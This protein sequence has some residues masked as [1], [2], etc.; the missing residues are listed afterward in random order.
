M[1][2][3]TLEAPTSAQHT[4][5]HGSKR[6][7]AGTVSTKITANNSHCA[8][9]TASSHPRLFQRQQTLTAGQVLAAKQEAFASH[10]DPAG[11]HSHL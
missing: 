4:T 10:E 1:F 5:Q 9:A 8:G 3:F 7:A 11:R 2:H 6:S